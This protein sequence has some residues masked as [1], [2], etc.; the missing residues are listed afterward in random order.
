MSDNNE[1]VSMENE[2]EEGPARTTSAGNN[3]ENSEGAERRAEQM[4]TTEMEPEE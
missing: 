2:N 1:D 4:T 3:A